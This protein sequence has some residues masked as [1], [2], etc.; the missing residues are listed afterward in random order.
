ME[1]NNKDTVVVNNY[2]N[3][4]IG[5]C[6]LLTIVFIVLKLTDQIDWS[7]FWVFSP[8]WIPI[9]IIV[10]VGC[11]ILAAALALDIIQKVID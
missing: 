4:G 1:M 10:S 9:A 8:M 6:S 2:H 3:E 11:L 7:W 5:F